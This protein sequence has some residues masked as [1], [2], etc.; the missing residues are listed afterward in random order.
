M[1]KALKNPP[2]E[3]ITFAISI[4]EY[5]SRPYV[6]EGFSK[7][8]GEDVPTENHAYILA[9]KSSRLKQEDKVDCTGGEVVRA[10]NKHSTPRILEALQIRNEIF[11]KTLQAN[12]SELKIIRPYPTHLL[13]VVELPFDLN[14]EDA[15]FFRKELEKVKSG[16]ILTISHQKGPCPALEWSEEDGRYWCSLID[17]FSEDEKKN[18]LKLG[19]G[20][21]RPDSPWRQHMN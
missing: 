21:G 7:R 3:S 14:H 16:P 20:C 11:D 17:E 2:T 19:R 5:F 12:C 15:A 6:V 1:V 10:L 9:P 18:G 13:T 8:F 4:A